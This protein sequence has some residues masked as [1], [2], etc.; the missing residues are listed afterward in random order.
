MDTGFYQTPI[1]KNNSSN[2]E[3]SENET[4]QKPVM[5]KAKVPEK[6]DAALLSLYGHIL[7]CA[8]SY[9]GAIGKLLLML[10]L[11]HI[12]CLRIERRNPLFSGY[13]SRAYSVKPKDPLISLSMGLAYMHRSMQRISDNRHLQIMQVFKISTL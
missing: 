9:V 13:Y 11:F 6:P 2:S 3:K 10:G 8:R 4:K 7:A 1:I 12:I 5:K